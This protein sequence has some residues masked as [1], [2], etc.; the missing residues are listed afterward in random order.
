MTFKEILNYLRQCDLPGIQSHKKMS[1]TNRNFEKP[2]N[3]IPSAVSILLFQKNNSIYFPLIKRSNN[4][5][6]HKNQI[7]LP[8]GKL[9]PNE[10]I[11]QCA[12]R[13]TNEEI[14][15]PTHQIFPV[16]NLTEL[17]I[18]VSNYIV[19]P[20]ITYTTIVPNFIFSNQEVDKIIICSINDLLHFTKQYSKVKLNTNVTIN[21]PSFIF[22]DEIIWGATALI[23]NEFKEILMNYYSV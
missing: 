12:I 23:L 7:A 17:Y 14:G 2:S 10:N 3:A 6:H 18:P 16:R 5:I 21:A 4:S 8:G 20:I 22:K 19:Y 9:E 15:I 1:F 13:E 11:F